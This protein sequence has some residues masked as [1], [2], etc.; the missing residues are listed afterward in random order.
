MTSVGAVTRPDYLKTRKQKPL[1]QFFQETLALCAP[2]SERLQHAQLGSPVE[3][4]GNYSYECNHS[5]G[6][7]YLLLGDAY[8]FIDPVF[9]SGVMMAMQSGFVGADTID[10]CLR[11]PQ[12][13]TTALKHFDEVVRVGPREFSWFIYRINTHTFRE[14]FMHPSNI[15]RVKEA[16]LSVL[17]G[18]L[19]GTTPIRRPLLMFKGLYYAGSLLSPRRAWKSWRMRKANVKHAALPGS[20]T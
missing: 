13:A 15:F 18:D 7:N 14:M 8:A 12:R 11:H 4:T 20:P 19:Y 3:A 6:S 9:S 2:L 5:H 17:A 1:E 10:T 16:L